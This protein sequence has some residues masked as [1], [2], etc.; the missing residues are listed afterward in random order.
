A[1]ESDDIGTLPPQLT[2]LL[3]HPLMQGFI[4][5]TD[6]RGPQPFKL[7]EIRTMVTGEV[8]VQDYARRLRVLR[9]E[10][11][12]ADADPF[13]AGDAIS[14]EAAGAVI[15]RSQRFDH[16][17]AWLSASGVGTR[18][19]FGSAC[20][21]L[22][23]AADGVEAGRLLRRLRLLGHVESAANGERWSMAPA[24]LA[25]VA[26]GAGWRGYVLCG[27]RDAHLLNTLHEAATVQTEPQLHGAGPARVYV[28][29]DDPER[30]EAH[31]AARALTRPPRMLRSAARLAEVLPA[32]DGWLSLLTVI[33]G[34]SPSLYDVRRYAGDGVF[35]SAAFTGETG[36]YE[37]WPRT[38]R[39]GQQPRAVGSYFYDAAR[40]R[41]LRGDWY[42]LRYLDQIRAGFACTAHYDLLSARLAVDSEARPP[43]IYERALVL[44]S[45]RLPV[46]RGGWLYYD[47]VQ[48]DV[49]N[50]I[51]TKLNLTLVELEPDQPE[52]TDA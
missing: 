4:P 13:P 42:G 26:S 37:L 45:G 43:E 5:R 51:A 32:I 10:P 7:D 40:D 9:S 16:L 47:G 17:L 49:L 50:A 22:G 11:S 35:E 44:C 41:W 38:V 20:H 2:P 39:P 24:V 14:A 15:D 3:A 25:E 46:Q 1:I 34:I 31:L 33:P 23:L 18:A 6:G 12:F 48:P 28:E 30:L 29:S 36:F 19:T 27:E 8:S 52:G 21:A